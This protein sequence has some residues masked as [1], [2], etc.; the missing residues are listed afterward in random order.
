MSKR[1]E[2]ATRK[3][4]RHITDAKR[5]E[6]LLERRLREQAVVAQFSVDALQAT[7]IQT[8]C[9]DATHIAA[10]ELRSDFSSVFER[11][12]DGET[13]LLRSAFGFSPRHVG[14]AQIKINEETAIGRAVQ[15]NRPIVIADWRQD[16]HFR[17]PQFMREQKAVS[18]M[19]VVVQ[20]R[21]HAFG[22][23]VVA[24]K[25]PRS[26]GPNEI[27]FLESIGNV[28]ATAISRTQ[29]ENEFRDTAARL[30]GIV[31]TAVDGIITIDERGIV[32]TMNPAAE[33]IFGYNADE[34]IGRNVSMLM[35]E[36]Y[37]SEHDGYLER[38]HRTGERRIIGIGREVRG[39]RKD[40]TEFPLDLAVSS[41]KL[42]HRRI[43]TGLLRDIT[44]RKRLE[45]GLLEISD[46]EQRRIGSDLHDDL[47]QRLAGI[48]FRC[49]A[50]RKTLGKSGS[51]HALER[52]EKIGTDV[53]DAI[54]RARMLARG[55]APVTLERNGLVSALQK[56][57]QAVQKLYG[58]K[59]TFRG[60]ENIAITDPVAATH[61][62]R[63]TQEAINNSLKHG[64][65]SHVVVSLQ[66][67]DTKAV[68]TIADDGLGFS[69]P[70]AHRTTEGMGLRT[71]AYRA[72]MIDAGF[73]VQSLPGEGTKIICTF[74]RDL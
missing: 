2:T 41:T 52:L 36:P 26:F 69:P 34:V 11:M 38:Y 51:D 10:R 20:G 24:S 50:L 74:S 70:E 23:L 67:R 19:A 49:D 73:Q 13:M 68:L 12:P 25:D 7:N 54:D 47:C 45:Q 29:F 8:I 35:P 5:N 61:L 63:I 9:D 72:G 21:E 53:G 32:E 15:L 33:R 58:V 71:I 31:D 48:R 30:E 27:H 17:M 1:K 6:Q 60:K 28:L 37:H 46:R 59:C 22:G 44:A 42:G 56:L 65:P 14:V 66:T 57:T 55:M 64:S 4:G 3:S 39:L 18:S 40:G 62:Y 43:F 16:T